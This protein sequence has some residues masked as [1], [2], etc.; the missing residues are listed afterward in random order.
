MAAQYDP[1]LAYMIKRGLPLDRETWLGDPPKPWCIEHEME[2]P[3]FWP[4]PLSSRLKRRSNISQARPGGLQN[5]R[6][7]LAADPC[8]NGATRRR[9]GPLQQQPG[10]R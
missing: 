1:V 4:D 2:V 9:Q 7:A 8:I 5:A 10:Q 3:E 6:H